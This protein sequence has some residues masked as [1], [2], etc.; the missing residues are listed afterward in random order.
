L[1]PSSS[2]H[3]DQESTSAS[4]KSQ[5][6][7]T[8]GS[9]SDEGV[10]GL[11]ADVAE[12]QISRFRESACTPAGKEDEEILGDVE[13]AVR[14]ASPASVWLMA[15]PIEAATAKHEYFF[16]IVGLFFGTLAVTIVTLQQWNAEDL[17]GSK[18]RF[19]SH[20]TRGGESPKINSFGVASGGCLIEG[21][22]NITTFD[23][24]QTAYLTFLEGEIEYDAWYWVTSAGQPDSDPIV[25]S[26]EV[27]GVSGRWETVGTSGSKEITQ[28][29]YHHELVEYPTPKDR[30]RLITFPAGTSFTYKANFI[31][32]SVL[33]LGWTLFF[34]F[35][36]IKKEQHTMRLYFIILVAS[37]GMTNFVGSLAVMQVPQGLWIPQ[38]VV[39]I[40][41][42]LYALLLASVGWGFRYFSELMLVVFSVAFVLYIVMDLLLYGKQISIR[43]I[44]L[45]MYSLFLF[46]LAI[47]FLQLYQWRKIKKLMEKDK[48]LNL[49]IWDKIIHK[50]GEVEGLRQ[51]AR[52]L[53]PYN[54]PTSKGVLQRGIEF[55]GSFET[56]GRLQ[57]L[58]WRNLSFQVPAGNT[59]I[60]V[61]QTSLS[62]L[63]H[64]AKSLQPFLFEKV[65]ELSLASNGLFPMTGD[66]GRSQFIPASEVLANPQLLEK[67]KWPPLKRIDRIRQKL[68]RCYNSDV[69]KLCDLCRATIVHRTAA[70][71]LACMDW[72]MNDED[73]HVLRTK[74][75]MD[76]DSDPQHLSA[77]RQISVNLMISSEG[78]KRMGV[79]MHVAEIQ[80]LLLPFAKIKTLDG[81]KR[82]IILRDARGE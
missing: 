80:L 31:S 51:V 24:K 40:M 15:N 55:H 60:G 27:Q 66:D 37:Y 67:V 7:P 4:M 18:F 8:V 65:R 35:K 53:Q 17:I 76:P 3:K 26:L 42:V 38:M 69:S 73:I 56:E 6:P 2:S 77:F 25:F 45:S 59:S 75:S 13:E 23:D 68:H 12:S 46:G 22:V 47:K 71:L 44:P 50:E 58:W 30:L 36:I 34:C 70:D 11:T 9:V 52:L 5:E 21:D 49:G 39:G 41:V 63:L 1:F 19:T 62:L 48:V 64:Q 78:T 32:S 72:L 28:D 82:Y 79:S 14:D 61:P 81:H 33:V 16:L 29:S 74:N 54:M 43:M 20:L 10:V 57:P